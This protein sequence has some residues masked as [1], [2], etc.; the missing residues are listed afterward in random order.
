MKGCQC[1]KERAFSLSVSLRLSLSVCLRRGAAGSLR[2][3]GR[4]A[5]GRA[6]PP[7]A[8]SAGGQGKRGAPLGSLSLWL[9]IT[10]AVLHRGQKATEV[11]HYDTSRPAHSLLHVYI[12]FL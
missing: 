7:L 8:S 5:G 3:G 2:G 1:V 11:V 6:V 4:G 9:C 10:Q 12:L